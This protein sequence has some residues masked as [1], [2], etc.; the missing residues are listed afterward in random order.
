MKRIAV[1]D[2]SEL[3]LESVKDALQEVGCQ[4][5]GML[6][7]SQREFAE[8]FDLILLDVNMPHGA[9]QDFISFFREAWGITAPIL[10]FSDLD[11][12]VLKK[13]AAE[14]GA[15]GYICKE[16]GMEELVRRVKSQLES[17]ATAAPKEASPPTE[18]LPRRFRAFAGL[19]VDHVGQECSEIVREVI[20]QLA[21]LPDAKVR[22]VLEIEAEAPHG[23]PEATQRS[24]SEKCKALK[25]ES[26]GFIR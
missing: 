17:H 10:L 6:E 14:S 26:H 8:D 5:V 16:W 19:S 22:V 12:A 23:V 4:V 25:F 9:G 21:V 11:E 15:D 7:P 18:N 3:V 24:V 20:Q 1:I 2:D 13:L